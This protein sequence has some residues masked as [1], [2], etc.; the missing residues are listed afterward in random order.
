M[1]V[2]RSGNREEVTT[3]EEVT[4]ALS[5]SEDENE[6]TVEKQ[7]PETAQEEIEE[8]PLTP[9]VEDDEEDVPAP[10]SNSG[11][12]LMPSL[13]IEVDEKKPP[14]EEA[15]VKIKLKVAKKFNYGGVWY[16]LK[17]NEVVN[18]PL[19]VKKRLVKLDVLL[20]L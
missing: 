12:T 15:M 11:V 18:V 2:K 19:N 6:E 4:V 16:D 13:T 7:E 8:K 10:V 14:V 5:P 3:V 20:P 17:A 1:A 9:P